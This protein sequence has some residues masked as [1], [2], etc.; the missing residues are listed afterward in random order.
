VL[1]DNTVVILSENL[2]HTSCSFTMFEF[3]NDNNVQSLL[4]HTE[5]ANNSNKFYPFFLNTEQRGTII[6]TDSQVELKI[7]KSKFCFEDPINVSIYPG[8]S[9][10]ININNIDNLYIKFHFQNS[11]DNIELLYYNNDIKIEN[12]TTSYLYSPN[13][14]QYKYNESS[15]AESTITY[16]FGLSDT[17]DSPVIYCNQINFNIK[18][19]EDGCAKCKSS[20]VGNCIECEAEKHVNGNVSDSS[21]KCG[22]PQ[23]LFFSNG[24]VQ[25]CDASCKT[26]T[27]N[28]FNCVGEC[29]GNYVK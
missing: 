4:T 18:T 21:F 9:E 1:N 2:S 27:E 5:L 26:C 7:Y 24:K 22:D 19:C 14:I 20:E 28:K 8:N 15:S 17:K 12:T 16:F 6:K 3:D 11:N 23:N 10:T 25:S 29:A 13:S